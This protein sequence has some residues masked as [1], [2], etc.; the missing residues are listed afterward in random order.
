M[1]PETAV[2]PVFGKEFE[3]RP[4]RREA[5]SVGFFC[6]RRKTPLRRL[7]CLPIS[8]I[9]SGQA[10]LC[11]RRYGHGSKIHPGF[12]SG[13]SHHSYKPEGEGKL[14]LLISV[15]G[16]G[17]GHRPRAEVLMNLKP[18]IVPKEVPIE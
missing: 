15:R 13:S 11:P 6:R 9:W 14:S 12:L 1:Q 17:V 10:F 16:Q 3:L 2:P 18:G 7:F 4:S 8:G 5:P